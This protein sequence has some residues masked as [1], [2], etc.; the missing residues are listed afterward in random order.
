MAPVAVALAMPA[1]TTT[2]AF[3]LPVAVAA[4][5]VAVV[6]GRW[7][8]SALASVWRLPEQRV[9]L[10][11]ASAAK[12]QVSALLLVALAVDVSAE[13]TR[14][15][16]RA[17]ARCASARARCALA[18]ARDASTTLIPQQ[19]RACLKQGGGHTRTAKNT[20]KLLLPQQRRK[21]LRGTR[22]ALA[23]S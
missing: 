15:R 9:V 5:P 22:C 18:S 14:A 3:A 6:A 10:V 12:Q 1:I 4:P 17:R 23:R 16:A 11:F 8:V 7:I 13:L 19:R 21:L 20:R 2:G